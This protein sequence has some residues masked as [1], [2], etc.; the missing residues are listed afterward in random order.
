[1]NPLHTALSLLVRDLRSTGGISLRVLD[2]PAIEDPAY[3][4]VWMLSD[5]DCRTGLLA[6]RDLPQP[7]RVVHVADQ[8]QD[9]VHEEL[10]RLGLPATWP[11]CPEHPA[12]HPLTPALPAGIPSW[13]CPK[14][15]RTVSTIGNL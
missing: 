13:Q 11:E 5:D 2:E 8:V 12:S 6:P 7:E 4:S 9:F 1:M 14:S 3:E 10:G 15:S